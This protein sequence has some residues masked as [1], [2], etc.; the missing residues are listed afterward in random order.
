MR[1]A[2]G[3][4]LALL[5]GSLAV[6]AASPTRP[7]LTSVS[8]LAVFAAD[9]AKSEAFYVH[10]LGA[11][12]MPDPENRAGVIADVIARACQRAIRKPISS[13]CR[14]RTTTISTK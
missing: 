14:K 11:V 12:K 10:D 8:H 9:P 5:A 1:R 6:A 4:V 2:I 7:P 3:S 13:C